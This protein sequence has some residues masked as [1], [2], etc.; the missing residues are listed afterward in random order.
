M[1]NSG[2]F[3]YEWKIWCGWL[4]LNW[5]TMLIVHYEKKFKI[6]FYILGNFKPFE[7]INGHLTHCTSSLYYVSYNFSSIQL[8]LSSC[9]T[10]LPFVRYGSSKF[11]CRAFFLDFFF[12]LLH[13]DTCNIQFHTCY[14]SHNQYVG[15]LVYL[16]LT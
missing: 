9:S 1:D 7:S 5:N 3:F 8:F 15:T 2:V 12:D 13:I 10:S 11:K 14:Q 16:K 6:W 4:K